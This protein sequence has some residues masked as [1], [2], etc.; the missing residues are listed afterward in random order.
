[1]RKINPNSIKNNGDYPDGMR[2]TNR[3]AAMGFCS[4]EILSRSCCDCGV[5]EGLIWKSIRLTQMVDRGYLL[6]AI[7]AETQRSDTICRRC[8]DNG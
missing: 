8:A 7:K 6:D 1:M 5:S 4:Q 3:L 2:E